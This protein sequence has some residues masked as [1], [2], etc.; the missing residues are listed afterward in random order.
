M[1]V[2]GGKRGGG[3]TGRQLCRCDFQLLPGGC[4]CISR[5]AR[6]PPVS[7][8]RRL[9]I[10]TTGVLWCERSRDRH[11]EASCR[12]FGWFEGMYGRLRG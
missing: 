1:I 5:V 4:C 11:V 6:G 7:G 3:G 8:S 10:G 12:K 2:A 9:R